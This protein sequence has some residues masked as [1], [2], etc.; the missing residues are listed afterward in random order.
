MP[1][2]V[3]NSIAVLSLAT[4][5]LGFIVSPVQALEDVDLVLDSEYEVKPPATTLV[6]H[7]IT[8]TNQTP[9]LNVR[10]FG[11][12]V[13]SPNLE[14]ISVITKNSDSNGKYTTPT[15]N[16]VPTDTQTSI[17]VQFEEPLVGQDKW[18]E[19]EISYLDPNTAQFTDQAGFV[20]VPTFL[21]QEAFD[22][23][24]V[25][26]TIPNEYFSEETE[27]KNSILQLIESNQETSTFQL[28]SQTQEPASL[29]FGEQQS[30]AFELSYLV[31]NQSDSPLLQQVIIPP[32]TA[33]QQV[34]YTSFDPM[35]DSISTDQ[36]NNWLASYRLEPQSDKKILITGQATLFRQ[37]QFTVSAPDKSLITPTPD[38]PVQT[39]PVTNWLEKLGSNLTPVDV[40][41]DI[42]EIPLSDT[43][44][45]DLIGSLE[46]GQPLT[47]IQLNDIL[48]TGHRS[49]SFPSR[50]TLGL[51]VNDE[52]PV[53]PINYP[54][55]TLHSWVETYYNQEWHRYDPVWEVT[56]GGQS[57]QA[58][59]DLKRL[60]LAFQTKS[61]HQ[62][63][64]EHLVSTSLQTIEQQTSAEK[65]ISFSIERTNWNGLKIPG[66]YEVEIN[67][68]DGTGHV[69]KVLS[70]SSPDQ[71][72][73]SLNLPS[74]LPFQTVAV[75]V[76]LH[77]ND[78]LANDQV[79]VQLELD[80]QIQ[81]VTVQRSSKIVFYLFG[82]PG[83][84][85]ASIL[86][87]GALGAGSVLVLK[88]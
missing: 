64:P 57:Y 2:V 19:I 88:R 70:I 60:S 63:W 74:L 40:Y 51:V 50:S 25:R 9:T 17:G 8:L 22:Q 44:T 53:R 69:N 30:V 68:Q 81:T 86:I 5:F 39:G 4:C 42:L 73:L 37:P 67:N 31:S 6:T 29:Y 41:E 71:A 26:V 27:S 24:N 58:V 80:D 85:A 66:Q 72:P 14:Q 20:F 12:S 54:D 18:Q 49:L 33:D 45:T 34:Q 79:S 46:Q 61:S 76:Q 15:V 28:N 77:S 62:P 23:I 48:I 56:T 59:H 43:L 1:N 65:N 13:A 16:I 82:W 32:S 78:W 47:P 11:F 3:R 52:D 10:Q 87:V 36:A 38:W 7:R 75:P 84:V 83:L 21:N 55:Q 35:P